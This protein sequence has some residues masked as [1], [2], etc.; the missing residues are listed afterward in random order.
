[1]ANDTFKNIIMTC[2]VCFGWQFGT[3]VKGVTLG[4]VS[5]GLGSTPAMVNL[6]QPNQPHASTQPSH[7]SVGRCNEYQPKGDDGLQ[8]RSEGRYSLCLVAGKTQ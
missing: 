4:L 1:M 3:V 8:M 2:Y 5:S 7:P 6:S